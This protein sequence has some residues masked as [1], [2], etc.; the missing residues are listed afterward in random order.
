MTVTLKFTYSY[1]TTLGSAITMVG[2]TLQINNA[3]RPSTLTTKQPNF[4]DF[5][6]PIFA[7]YRVISNKVMI[8][9]VNNGT[10]PVVACLVPLGDTSVG[11]YTNINEVREI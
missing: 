10:V 4:Y 1:A 8:T 2:T 6:T 11:T 3:Y 9:S 7:R 5:Y